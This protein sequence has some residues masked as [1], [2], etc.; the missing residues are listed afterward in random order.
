MINGVAA[1]IHRIAQNDAEVSAVR[2]SDSLLIVKVVAVAAAGANK[3][4]A[5]KAA[6][7]RPRKL[8]DWCFGG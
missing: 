1:M 2:R 7:S 6:N 8:C 5:A 4:K 3:V